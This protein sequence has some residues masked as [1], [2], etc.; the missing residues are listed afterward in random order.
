M[1]AIA[2]YW[3]AVIGFIAPGATVVITSL[4]EGTD[5]GTR[6]TGSEWL[7]ALMTAI[8]SAAAVYTVPNKARRKTRKPAARPAVD[9]DPPEHRAPGPAI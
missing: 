4:V 3:K 6:V 8:V 1:D 5:G 9:D 2:P 7:M